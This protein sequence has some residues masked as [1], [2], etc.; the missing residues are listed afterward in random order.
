MERNPITDQLC[1]FPGCQNGHDIRFE[2]GNQFKF[3]EG[4]DILICNHFTQSCEKSEAHCKHAVS[5]MQLHLFQVHPEVIPDAII[6]RLLANFGA[7]RIVERSI[8]KSPEGWEKFKKRLAA[9]RAMK[10]GLT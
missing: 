7:M 5:A 8:E 6:D 4:K 2:C 3:K 10:E 9:R 1:D